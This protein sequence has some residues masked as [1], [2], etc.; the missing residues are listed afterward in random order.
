MSPA[1]WR[2]QSIPGQAPLRA[3]LRY[4]HPQQHLDVMGP[5]STGHVHPQDVPLARMMHAALEHAVLHPHSVELI[6]HCLD[7]AAPC[8]SFK[9]RLQY[10]AAMQMVY[11]QFGDLHAGVFLAQLLMARPG[12]VLAVLALAQL[13]ELCVP[14]DTHQGNQQIV[15]YGI[16]VRIIKQYYF[17]NKAIKQPYIPV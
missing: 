13:S 6:I 7:G 8:W 9:E 16:T 2:A 4:L 11:G 1:P 14:A 17:Q 3:F 12:P 15:K 5:F 10:D